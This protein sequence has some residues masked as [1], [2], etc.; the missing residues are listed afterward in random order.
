[1]KDINYVFIIDLDGTI[2]GDCIYQSELFKIYLILKKL[3]INIKINEILEPCYKEKS[4]LIRPYFMKFIREMRNYL[5][6][7]SFYIYTAS[8]KSWAEREISIIERSLE[9]KFNRPI[10]TRNDCIRVEDNINNR[11]DYKKSLELIRKK[12]KVKN[13]EILIIDDKDV[14]IDNND[15][16]IRCSLYNYK[17]F[18]NYWDNMP[19][20]CRIK[21]KVFLGY[22]ETLIENNR[23]NPI[24]R[25]TTMKTKIKYYKWLAN[26]CESINRCNRK[27]KNDRFWEILTKTIV[28]NKIITF[29][30]ISIRFIENS[31]KL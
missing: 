4:R 20:L 23:L 15:K 25:I 24:S 21:N 22:L 30:N 12:I 9:I 10:F 28:E 6:S 1:M 14:Y 13:P 31:L 7:V 2:I 16:L 27:Y 29:N 5:G 18:C 17:F 11:I 8:E 3:G 19:E 26:R